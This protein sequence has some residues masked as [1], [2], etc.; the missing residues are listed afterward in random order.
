MEI[1]PLWNPKMENFL[2]GWGKCSQI[3]LLIKIVMANYDVHWVLV[4]QR[5]R[6]KTSNLIWEKIFK[7]PT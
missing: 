3:F 7:R 1:V 2:W 4:D 5:T 6:F